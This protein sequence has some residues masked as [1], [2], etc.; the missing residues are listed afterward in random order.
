MEMISETALYLVNSHVSSGYPYPKAPHVKEISGTHID[1][2]PL[3]KVSSERAYF[4]KYFADVEHEQISGN[5][6]LKLPLFPGLA[7]FYGRRP[8]RSN[9]FQPG[10][11]LEPG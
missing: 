11:H 7:R 10:L 3:P 1:P 4:P 5:P 8:A 2:Q 6:V 9:I